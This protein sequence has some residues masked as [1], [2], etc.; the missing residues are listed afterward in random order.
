MS[1]TTVKN[2]CLKF[3]DKKKGYRHFDNALSLSHSPNRVLEGA[4]GSERDDPAPELV[5]GAFT[6]VGLDEVIT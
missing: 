4:L 1:E 6:E 5:L 2:G 3:G